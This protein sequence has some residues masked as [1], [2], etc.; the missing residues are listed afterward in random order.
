MHYNA[1][2]RIKTRGIAI[3]PQYFVGTEEERVLY[4]LREAIDRGE[5]D[6]IIAINHENPTLDWNKITPNGLSALWWAL[7]P[8][9][10]EDI[11]EGVVIALLSLRKNIGDKPRL[12]I[13]PNQTYN[14]CTVAQYLR[15]YAPNKAAIPGILRE[16][17]IEWEKYNREQ[18]TEVTTTLNLNK[19]LARAAAT[20]HS[21][22]EDA[23]VK[24]SDRNI[25]RL[26]AI[27]GNDRQ[28]LEKELQDIRNFFKSPDFIK[29]FT[30]DDPQD[31]HKRLKRTAEEKCRI[32]K[33]GFD[34]IMS[35]TTAPR[36]NGLTLSLVLALVWRAAKDRDPRYLPTECVHPDEKRINEIV[37]DRL[38]EIFDG[39]LYRSQDAYGTPTGNVSCWHGFYGSLGTSL[40][41]MHSQV[42]YLEP[43]KPLPSAQAWQKSR[44]VIGR[45]LNQVYE[46]DKALY[47]CIL[48]CNLDDGS[49]PSL[50]NP[51]DDASYKQWFKEMLLR[52]QLELVN[53]P[54]AQDD[55]GQIS[56]AMQDSI[57]IAV[58]FAADQLSLLQNLFRMVD[59]PEE[60]SLTI[61]N[62]YLQKLQTEDELT[63]IQALTDIFLEK[64][65]GDYLIEKKLIDSEFKKTLAFKSTASLFLEKRLAAG[66]Q[67]KDE[68]ELWE[69]SLLQSDASA[70]QLTDPKLQTWYQGLTDNLRILFSE[71]YK[72]NKI[73]FHHEHS[74]AFQFAL[75]HQ[76]DF[77]MSEP[78]PLCGVDLRGYKISDLGNGNDLRGADLRLI[79]LTKF[80]TGCY[81]QGA[82]FQPFVSRYM[83]RTL[84]QAADVTEEQ[85]V[86]TNGAG[87]TL[88]HVAI[89][90]ND[91]KTI[92]ALLTSKHFTE[93]ILKKKRLNLGQWEGSDGTA[94]QDAIYHNNYAM[95]KLILDAYTQ[96]MFDESNCLYLAIANDVQE[97][98]RAVLEHRYFGQ[99]EKQF[100]PE[101][102]TGA[103]C[104]RMAIY[105]DNLEIVKV[106]LQSPHCTEAVLRGSAC[107]DGIIG[108]NKLEMVK[109]ILQSPHCTEA[110]LRDSAALKNAI[111]TNNSQMVQAILDAPHFTK[112]MFGESNCLHL[113][114]KNNNQSTIK[115][116]LEHKYCDSSFLK[117][118]NA[119]GYSALWKAV[120]ENSQEAA[121]AIL[122]SP[123]CTIEMLTETVPIKSNDREENMT[124]LEYAITKRAGLVIQAILDYGEGAHNVFGESNFKTLRMAIACGIS[125]EKIT[126]I[127][128]SRYLAREALTGRD[129]LD[130]SKQTI[131]HWMISHPNQDYVYY[132]KP[133]IKLILSSSKI[134]PEWLITERDSQQ[135]TI[136]HTIVLIPRNR[137]VFINYNSGN[138]YLEILTNI[139]QSSKATTAFLMAKNAKGNT[140][141]HLSIGNETNTGC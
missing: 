118:K 66:A 92:H 70:A 129:P 21:A 71:R 90:K 113:A 19:R 103:S 32:A 91:L 124:L 26:V 16:S 18:E 126:R 139:L 131:L 38:V 14:G 115:T 94:L 117:I 74:F 33:L 39:A 77:P 140:A 28:A 3:V 86:Q 137:F 54:A 125:L 67:I 83:A 35:L 127:L 106:I 114:I 81:L 12:V 46:K 40:C 34:Y 87:E 132:F 122:Q 79:L 55:I 2:K 76:C 68:K 73:N 88:L 61:F 97:S 108:Q 43:G 45:E 44:A 52:L 13:D 96:E 134:T 80:V 25:A 135:N 23:T 75:H 65:I 30:D 15:D 136:L 42:S 31:Q 48:R 60:Q 49:E 107:L 141:L 6:E 78:V 11:K 7:T 47:W 84:A 89:R 51:G 101:N 85:F 10:G 72:E 27:Y 64:F 4:R 121:C 69:L 104:L 130:K 5:I 57:P 123:H 102:N 9:A 100:M 56:A 1:K 36:D 17:Q 110:V 95:V 63:V 50:K 133:I 62:Q 59:N 22:S 120:D 98:I 128:N 119:N 116:I 99:S 138:D 112:K 111:F 82:H 8:P 20:E 29:L 105:K 53:A 93:D 41:N 37:R 24:A 109:V 58:R